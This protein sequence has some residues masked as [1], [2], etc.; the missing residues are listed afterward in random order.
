M[1]F[2]ISVCV[3][4][5]ALFV[6]FSAGDDL[7]SKKY[8]VPKGFE[9]LL[10]NQIVEVDLLLA[11]K[12]IGQGQITMSDSNI[13]FNKLY[14]KGG[15]FKSDALY[16]VQEQLQK[17][18]SP[19]GVICDDALH[20]LLGCVAGNRLLQATY[21]PEKLQ[22]ELV[23]D[24]SLLL[25]SKASDKHY[26][27]LSSTNQYSAVTDYTLNQSYTPNSQHYL[28][29]LGITL[30]KGEQHIRSSV[31]NVFNQSEHNLNQYGELSELYYR[32][33]QQ[34][35]QLTAGLQEQWNFYGNLAGNML[36]HP[37]EDVVALSWGASSQTGSPDWAD[38]RIPSSGVYGR[39][40]VVSKFIGTELC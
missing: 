12:R 36:F 10:K 23:V 20:P 7:P 16:W 31:R 34:G 3:L 32:N 37:R 13:V 9:H 1:A 19:R 39:K 26:L 6:R 5:L 18:I 8:K 35:M 28:L 11:G 33:D 27:P 38:A 17:G 22:V 40:Q 30:A 15:S 14:V 21:N 24:S 4:F 2:Y 25:S 29:G